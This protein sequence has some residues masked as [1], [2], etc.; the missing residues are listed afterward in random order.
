MR[1]PRSGT[2][3]GYKTV[4][5]IR[6]VETPSCSV[7]EPDKSFRRR[8]SCIGCEKLRP[9]PPRD[10]HKEKKPRQRLSLV[11][12]LEVL[13]RREQGNSYRAIANQM[14][15]PRATVQSVVRQYAKRQERVR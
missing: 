15:L 10:G 13:F 14:G 5:E 6:F 3:R 2:G 11:C 1:S 8:I 9:R 7:C 4:E 12:K